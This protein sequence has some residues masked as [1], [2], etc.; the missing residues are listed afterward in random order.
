MTIQLFKPVYRVDET[1]NEIRECLVQGWTGIG[2]KCV[3]FEDKFKTY[4][5][6]PHA[7]FLN[8]ATAGLH[9]ALKIAL[10]R[11]KSAFKVISTPL[12]F[13]STN[14]AIKYTGAMPIFVDV[15]DSLCMDPIRLLEVL[16]EKEV[17]ETIGAILFMAMGGNPGQLFAIQEIAKHYDIPL[18][19]DASH[20]C[21]SRL[22]HEHIGAGADF[23]VFSFQAVKNLSTGD[24]GMI[25]CKDE[26]DDKLAR[27]LSWLGIS[28][29][30]HLRDSWDYEVD[31]I[32]WK[33]HGNAIAAAI[34]IVGLKYL[35]EDN[36]YRRGIANT[37]DKFLDPGITKIANPRYALDLSSN[38]LYQIL[39]DLNIRNKIIAYAKKQ[40]VQLGVHYKDNTNYPMYRFGHCPNSH[41]LSQKLISLPMGC[42]L[43]I[44]DATKVIGVVNAGYSLA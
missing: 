38:H 1:L 28:K 42:H 29:P 32:G 30:T 27:K 36:F 3:E 25:C 7:H 14:H 43:T 35:N 15:D 4:T 6:L 44:D 26:A 13:I 24:G 34:G 20:A 11:N 22:G 23:T 21:G 9:I 31:E 10:R 37:Y 5:K 33:Y 17:R 16:G 40:G 19:V 39:V 41:H 18:I 8:S 12:T 2:G